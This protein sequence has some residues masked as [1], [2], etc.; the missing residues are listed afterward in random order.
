MDDAHSVSTP[1]VMKMEMEMGMGMGIGMGMGMGMGME[2]G[3]GD[4][5]QGSPAEG[6]QA[7]RGAHGRCGGSGAPRT[8]R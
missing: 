1:D 6:P 5:S 2:M 4:L 8:A 7:S 3:V